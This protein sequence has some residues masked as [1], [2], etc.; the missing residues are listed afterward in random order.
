[1][2]RT[3][4]LLLVLAAAAALTSDA[5]ALDWRSFTPTSYAVET[6][7]LVD[8]E[9]FTYYRLTAD[10]PL[11]FSVDGPT[12]LKILTRLRLPNDVDAEN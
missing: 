4:S 5:A 11:V 6:Q 12:R 2:R 8:G 9:T 7:M 10:E 3:V 1:M